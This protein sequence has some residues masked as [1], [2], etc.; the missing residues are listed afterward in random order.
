MALDLKTKKSIRLTH[1]LIISSFLFQIFAWYLALYGVAPDVEQGNIYRILFV[2]VPVA[3][4]SFFWIFMGSVFGILSLIKQASCAQYDQ[5]SHSAME[6]GAL[7]SFL[8]LVTGSVWGRPTW[9]VW[10]DWD[11][12]LT[13]SLV[14]FLMCCGYLVLRRFTPNIQAQRR[15]ASIVSILAAVNVPVV[16]YSVNLWRSL[17]QPQSFSKNASTT[18]SDIALVLCINFIAMFFVSIALFRQRK[19]AI[20]AKEYLEISRNI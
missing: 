17:H 16:Y 8:V 9:G 20:A 19:Q 11:P 12:R 2:H 13:S 4:C 15:T 6:L 14:M 5:K 3:W 18:S 7:F 10:W 1:I